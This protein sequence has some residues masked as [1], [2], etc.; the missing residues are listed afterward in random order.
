MVYLFLADGFEEVE[1]L[2][3]LDFLRR[4]GV[5]VTTVCV[6]DALDKVATGSHKISV[7]CDISE[8]ELDKTAPFD[9]IILP[10]GLPGADNLNASKVVSHYIERATSEDKYICAICAAPYIL[11]ERGVLKGKE[12]CC[13][14]GFENKLVGAT[15][16]QKGVVRD[17]KI[18]TSRA[19]GKAIDFALEIIDALCG[20]EMK[21]KLSTSVLYNKGDLL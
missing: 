20:K 7:A 1:A 18:I 21:E 2:T 8:R 19:M 4:A 10:G 3:P 9:M 13:Y 12:A 6:G 17:G 15:V 14:P 16:S 11:G 5:N